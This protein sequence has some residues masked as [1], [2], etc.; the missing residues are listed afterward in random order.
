MCNFC[1]LEVE[2]R[3]NLLCSCMAAKLVWKRFLRLLHK[4]YGSTV[5]KWGTMMWVAINGELQY[6][7]KEK[8]NFALYSRGRKV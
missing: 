2:S 7:E 6:C 1:G 5:Y 3:H 4:V 8:A